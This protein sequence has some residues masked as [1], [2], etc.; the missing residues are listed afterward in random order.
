MFL[1]KIINNEYDGVEALRTVNIKYALRPDHREQGKIDSTGEVPKVVFSES[2]G[3][4]LIVLS[5]N[6]THFGKI[7]HAN[8]EI[9]SIFGFQRKE[10]LD[11]HV[12]CLMP[13]LIAKYHDHFVRKFLQSGNIRFSDV[14][15]Q[16]YAQNKE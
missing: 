9:E 3:Y 14:I 7:L 16:S 12:T 11:Q 10:L 13:H 15:R 2:Q 8:C 4:G 5:T 6:S 1:I